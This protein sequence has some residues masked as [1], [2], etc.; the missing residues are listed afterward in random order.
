MGALKALLVHARVGV[1]TDTHSCRDLKLAGTQATG[2][3]ACSW[4]SVPAYDHGCK[5]T[6]AGTG[7]TLVARALAATASRA[8]RKVAFF[9]R[10]GADVLSKW[11]GEAERQLRLLFE[12]AARQQPSIIFFDEIDGLAPVRSAVLTTTCKHGPGSQA[13][14]GLRVWSVQ[15]CRQSMLKSLG[16]VDL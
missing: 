3:H 6:R 2:M 15:A 12:E 7:K 16:R 14:C 11:V 5:G 13:C 4:E 9:M 1:L 8:G 10:K